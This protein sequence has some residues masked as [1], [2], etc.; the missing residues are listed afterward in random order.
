MG[1]SDNMMKTTDGMPCMKSDYVQE[2]AQEWVG[3]DLEWRRQ[4]KEEKIMLD[5]VQ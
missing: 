2:K 4:L 1:E 3:A 5:Q